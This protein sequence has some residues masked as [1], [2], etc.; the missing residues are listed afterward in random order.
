MTGEMETET[1][2]ETQ[3]IRDMEWNGMNGRDRKN[4]G[5]LLFFFFSSF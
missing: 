3:W 5:L 1:D 4:G 2:M